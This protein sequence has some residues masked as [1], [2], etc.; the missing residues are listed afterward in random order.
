MGSVLK[1]ITYHT[2]N[3]TSSRTSM[4]PMFGDT[5][6]FDGSN[7]PTWSNNISSI[8]TLKGVVGYLDSTVKDPKL[9]TTT[10]QQ[11]T[12]SPQPETPWNS[13]NPTTDKWEIR[14]A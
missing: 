1:D 9:N 14:N 10:S 11:G 3:M 5:D 12:I 6:K 8:C 4:L 13:L 7:W 2:T